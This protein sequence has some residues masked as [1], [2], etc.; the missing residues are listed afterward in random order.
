MGDPIVWVSEVKHSY[1]MFRGGR[2]CL[3]KKTSDKQERNRRTERKS[4]KDERK[5][6]AEK[7]EKAKEPRST[8]NKLA[9][10]L[11][12]KAG[13]PSDTWWMSSCIGPVGCTAFRER[14]YM[15]YHS[16][17]G[18]AHSRSSSWPPFSLGCQLVAK[19]HEVP[20]HWSSLTAGERTPR[21]VSPHGANC[22]RSFGVLPYRRYSC[23]RAHF[24]C[25][26]PWA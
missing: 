15:G 12:R 2:A 24:L 22:S 4:R 9:V 7:K 6:R 14:L 13:G 11:G 23:R 1:A 25:C 5:W 21:T 20:P 8:G 19:R 18:V 26:V 17:S 3:Q 10:V 16:N